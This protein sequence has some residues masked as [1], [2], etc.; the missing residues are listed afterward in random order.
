VGRTGH[1]HA[2]GREI[3]WI[4][5]AGEYLLDGRIM[6]EFSTVNRPEGLTAVVTMSRRC[7]RPPASRR[8]TRWRRRPAPSSIE[9]VMLQDISGA[10]ASRFF[11]IDFE[12]SATPTEFAQQ[13]NEV[14]EG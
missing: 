2:L 13:I 1:V 8:W 12:A 9:L 3:A 10:Q 5:G 6:K 14:S 11:L 7:T 4:K